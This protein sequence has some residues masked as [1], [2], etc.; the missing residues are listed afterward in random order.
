MTVAL[1]VHGVMIPIVVVA[2]ANGGTAWVSG[3]FSRSVV[4]PHFSE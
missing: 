1:Q 2:H 3:L 4:V